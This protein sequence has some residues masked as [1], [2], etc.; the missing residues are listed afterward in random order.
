MDANCELLDNAEHSDLGT[1]PIAEELAERLEG[2]Q[3]G[4]IN[5]WNYVSPSGDMEV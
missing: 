2:D 1:P 5:S 4:N 3:T